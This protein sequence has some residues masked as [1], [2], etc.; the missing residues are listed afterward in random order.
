MI[1]IATAARQERDSSP[2]PKIG[3]IQQ[4][5]SF[6]V[7][8]DIDR[9]ATKCTT[10]ETAIE[11]LGCSGFFECDVEDMG[12]DPLSEMSSRH[13]PLYDFRDTRIDAVALMMENRDTGNGLVHVGQY[14]TASAAGAW[15]PARARGAQETH[16]RSAVSFAGVTADSAERWLGVGKLKPDCTSVSDGAACLPARAES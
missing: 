13:R 16:D 11:P 15:K 7:P 4:A 1:Q 6:H 2:S 10:A 5:G 14:P 12:G 9:A 3:N 8:L